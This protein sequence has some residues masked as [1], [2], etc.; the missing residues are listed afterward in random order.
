MSIPDPITFAQEWQAAWNSHDLDRIL[1]HYSEDVRFYSNKALALIGNGEISGKVALRDYWGRALA[2]QPDLTFA[3]ADVFG[4]YRMQVI[5]YINHQ[6][7]GAA[8]TLYFND[9]GLVWLAS[10]CHR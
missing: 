3:V 1:A 9:A 5:T 2:G 6:G 4:G 8:E 7:V 10:A